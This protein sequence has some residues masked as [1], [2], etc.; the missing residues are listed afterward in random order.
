RTGPGE[1]RTGPGEGRTG[2]G[3]GRTGPGE[4]RTG[5]GECRTGPGECRTGPGECR[6]GPGSGSFPPGHRPQARPHGPA[7]PPPAVTEF[8]KKTGDYPS[9]SAADLQVLALTCQLQTEIDGP[10][11]LRWEPQDKVRLS[12]TPRHPEAPLHLAGFHLPAKHKPAGKGPSQPGPGSGSA[13]GADSDQFGS[14][15]YWRPPLPSIEGELLVRRESP[16]LFSAIPGS[17]LCPPDRLLSPRHAQAISGSPEPLEDH[18]SSA[19]GASAGEEEEEED[20]ESDDEGW[21]TPS[22]LKQ[23]QQDTGQ[24]DTAPTGIQV[25]C[26]T[27]D[28]AMQNVL[29]QMGLH[30]LAV[31]GMLIRRARSYILRCHGCFRTTSDMTKVFCPHCGNKTLKKVAVSV[32]DDGSLHMHFSRNPKVLNPRG[33]R[34]SMHAMSSQFLGEGWITPSNLKQAQQDTGQCDTAP[35]GIQVGCVTTDFAMQNVLLQMG[36]HVLAVNGMLI[37]RARSYILR[38][39]G[40]FRTTSDM[41]KVFCPHCGNKTLKKVA[42]SVSDDGS[43]HMHFSRNPKVLNPRGLRYPLPAPQG[44]KHANNPHLVEDQR[45]PQQ[46][47][48]RKARQKTNVFDPDYLAGA[49]PFAENDVHSRAAHLQLRDAA[50]GAG[51]RRLNPNAVSKKFVKRR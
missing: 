48:S 10:G 16:A 47:L 27:T 38:C 40:C 1:Y 39:H 36:L 44:G 7:A 51:R 17:A 18:R 32:S 37:R 23:A 21:I 30:V 34:V 20:E 46:R 43:L 19:D 42:V 33:L 41:T 5:P 6:R 31:N 14:F 25:G 11:C 2:P 4:C 45:F 3:E 24:C 12:S 9:L 13:P 29:L 8:S 28:F 49:S 50:L 15:L 35:T 22:N 26:V